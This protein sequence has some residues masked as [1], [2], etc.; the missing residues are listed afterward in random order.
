MRKLLLIALLAVGCTKTPAPQSGEP[1][2]VPYGYRQI[3]IMDGN[4][5]RIITVPVYTSAGTV[6][7]ETPI[8]KLPEPIKA[9]PS[10]KMPAGEPIKPPAMKKASIGPTFH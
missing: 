3:T 10:Q 8:Q 9:L 1:P 4:G 5:P 2:Q 7:H 6:I